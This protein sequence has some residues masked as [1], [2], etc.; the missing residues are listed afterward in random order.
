M[1]RW[2]LRLDPVDTWFFRDGRPFDAAN[3][4][5]GGLPL[6]QVLAGALRTALLARHDF[7]FARFSRLRTSHPD[8]DVRQHLESCLASQGHWAFDVQVRGPWL[9]LA[10]DGGV[11]PLLRV[12]A[13][14]SC[15]EATD[16]SGGTW[17]PSRPWEGPAPAWLRPRMAGAPDVNLLPLWRTG[18]PD[19]KHPGGFL[20]LSGIRKVLRQQPPSD[21]DWFREEELFGSDVRTGIGVD[22]E[23][24]TA[25]EGEI[26][27][28]QFLAVKPRVVRDRVHPDAR[29]SWQGSQVCLYAE[30]CGAD[31]AERV[32]EWLTEPIPL[33][34]EGRYAVPTCVT[35]AV[36]W[37]QPEPHVSRAMWLLASPGIY[38]QTPAW[39][40]D[41]IPR[42]QLRAA[43]SR[44][45]QAVSGW[46]VARRAPR[47]T[48][49][50]V[51]AGSVYF[52][53]G[54]FLPSGSQS[55]CQDVEDV[56][57]GWGFALQGAW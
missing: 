55:L 57:Q 9:A 48:R 23:S 42:S 13:C 20:T 22:M 25:G 47:P 17:V 35:P 14:W 19:A 41:A 24:L 8:H 21:T 33:G 5:E 51:P 30:L 45:P 29:D 27:G 32:A 37:P 26:Y 4:V 46:D 53:D 18:H 40:P 6:P 49:F 15:E 38:G 39:L 12:P 28:I 2:G 34:G 31:P 16:G 36:D 1:N 43:A 44:D 7:D 3:R 52:V 50:A 56:A 11:E 10:H 54:P